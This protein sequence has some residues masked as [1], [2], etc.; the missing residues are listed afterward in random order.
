MDDQSFGTGLSETTT[1]KL[2]IEEL[3]RLVYKYSQYQ[4]NDP[5]EIVKLAVYNCINGDN[6]LLDDKLDL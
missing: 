5:E 2:K 1:T 6:T 4:N 3:K